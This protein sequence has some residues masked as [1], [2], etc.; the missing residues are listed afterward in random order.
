[1]KDYGGKKG[2]AKAV[3]TDLMHLSIT[4]AELT[5]DQEKDWETNN[6]SWNYLVVLANTKKVHSI[7]SP[8]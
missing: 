7:S 1:M 3:L 8:H 2:W 5:V 6:Y 4:K